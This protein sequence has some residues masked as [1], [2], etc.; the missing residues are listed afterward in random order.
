MEKDGERDKV[1]E[2]EEEEE[3]KNRRP[4]GVNCQWKREQSYFPQSC[5]TSLETI[6]EPCLCV[7]VSV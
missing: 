2:Q 5:W 7:S 1:K 6:T 4:V 3:E